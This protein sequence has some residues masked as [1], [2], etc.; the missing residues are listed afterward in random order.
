MLGKIS[1]G[2][3]ISKKKVKPKKLMSI[4]I[5]IILI[6]V[7]M[8]RAYYYIKANKESITPYTY[9]RWGMNFEECK[10]VVNQLNPESKVI[11]EEDE[12]I[13]CNISDYEGRKDID[14]LVTLS[15]EEDGLQEMDAYII[16]R[17][18]I[19]YTKDELIKDY[20]EMLDGLCGKHEKR[21]NTYVWIASRSKIQLI[22][23]ADNPVII[24]YQ[25]VN[26]TLY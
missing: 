2:I 15:C 10:Q 4:G 21:L 8:S 13:I 26:K 19:S 11:L 20:V 9:A 5:L 1:G 7:F 3:Q 12:K 23:L 25:W 6:G 22:D 18:G 16:N 17:R 14:A 24:R